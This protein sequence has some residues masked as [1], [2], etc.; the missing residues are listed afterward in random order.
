L[1]ASPRCDR[2]IV[3]LTSDHGFHLGEK[4]HLEKFALW[5]KTTRVPLIVVAPRVTT[6]GTVCTHP[7]DQ[8]SLYPTLLELCGL[9]PEEVCDGVSIAGLLRNPNTA[10]WSQ[11]AV[12]SYLQNNHAVRSERW[13]Y[14][15]YADATEELYDHER[16]PHEWHN[17][18][19]DPHYQEVIQR[20]R[21]YLPTQNA[22]PVGDLKEPK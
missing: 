1:D 22:K 8:M 4:N 15:R 9:R 11:P 17:L 13:R 2:T 14:I 21:E 5:E 18:A 7:V 6:P 20:H 12:M 3:V 10:D 19:A 16:D